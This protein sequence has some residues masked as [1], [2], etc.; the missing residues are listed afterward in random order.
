MDYRD[1]YRAITESSAKKCACKKCRGKKRKESNLL[2]YGYE[3]FLSIPEVQ[4]RKIKTCI[5]KYGGPSPM[6][7]EYIKLKQQNVLI[8]KYGVSNAS[9]VEEFQC[10]KAQTKYKNGTCNT[11][12]EQER[13]SK[14]FSGKLNY[15][16]G[17]YNADILLDNKIILEYDGDGHNILVKYKFYTEDDFVNYE[18]QRTD[19]FINKGYRIIRFIRLKWWQFIT[20]EEYEFAMNLCM[21]YISKYNE[22]KYDFANKKIIL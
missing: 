8:E 3:E 5:D 20:D 13:L 15:P 4:Q 7:S 2:K 9:Q 22:V 12:K 18:K 6:N 21:E 16:I 19:Y 11:S 10:K 1:Y 14:L 17:K